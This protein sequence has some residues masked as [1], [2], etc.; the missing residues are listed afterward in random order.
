MLEC[1]VRFK[2]IQRG[3]NFKLSDIEA[4]LVTHE[5]GDHVQGID[6]VLKVGINC[7]MSKG[8]A[9]AI[10][11]DH[12]RI[13][14]VKAKEPFVIGTWKVMPFDVQHD[15]SEP[16]GFLLTSKYGAKVLFLTD[17]YYCK[18]RFNGVTHLLV[19]CNYSLPI[20]DANIEMGITP[21]AMRKRLLKSHFS[22]ENVKDF[23]KANDLSRVEEIY[24]LHLSDSN[25]DEALFKEEV[26]R[27]TGKMVVVA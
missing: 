24:L 25:S 14:P 10:G 12:H 27:L 3:F 23:L 8:T 13:K 22:L 9:D 2:D 21:K 11:K 15:V 18:Y 5:H 6:G 19:E 7:Y 17:T 16:F 4:C 26:A 1:G 20:L